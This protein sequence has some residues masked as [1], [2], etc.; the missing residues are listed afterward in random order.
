[1]FVLVSEL[2]G[3]I[4]GELNIKYEQSTLKNI[5]II[6]QKKHIIQCILVSVSKGPHSQQIILKIVLVN[7]PHKRTSRKFES[8]GTMRQLCRE[9]RIMIFEKNKFKRTV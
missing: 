6:S 5:K 9:Y 2:Q 7:T 1:M 3:D 4:R 8:L